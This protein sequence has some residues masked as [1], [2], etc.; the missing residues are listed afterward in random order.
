MRFPLLKAEWLLLYA[1]QEMSNN[2]AFAHLRNVFSSTL[3]LILLL[4]AE[5]N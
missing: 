4:S 1:V 3:R 5:L 2:S